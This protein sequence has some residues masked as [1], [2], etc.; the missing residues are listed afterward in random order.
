M[1]FVKHTF[2]V[3]KTLSAELDIPLPVFE[4]TE[5]KGI[6]SKV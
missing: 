5:D 1:W 4:E 6:D 2:G 3:L